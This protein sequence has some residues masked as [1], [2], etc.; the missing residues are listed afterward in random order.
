MNTTTGDKV[1]PVPLEGNPAPPRAAV[2]VR[3]FSSTPVGHPVL[4]AA[5]GLATQHLLRT[6][7]Q[8]MVC[9]PHADDHVV[10]AAA[11]QI[12][13]AEAA[14]AVLID[15]IDV[16]AATELAEPRTGVLHTE[17]LGQLVERLAIGWTRWTLLD[18]TDTGA[19]PSPARAA[20]ARLA[21]YQLNELVSAYDDLVTDLQTHRRCLPRFQT[22]TGPAATA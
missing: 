9:D 14:C 7:V 22:P 8:R 10:A 12:T 2:V 16:W 18:T 15:R 3:A 17:T 5:V 4:S 1:I 19:D 13:A 20:Q 6:Q 11:R 21:L